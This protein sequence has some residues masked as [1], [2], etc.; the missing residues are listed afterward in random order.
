[1]KKTVFVF[2]ALLIFTIASFSQKTEILDYQVF[3]TKKLIRQFPRE[4]GRILPILL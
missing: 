1:M 3:M 4:Y 2:A